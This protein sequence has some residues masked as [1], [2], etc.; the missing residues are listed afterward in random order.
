MEQ[1]E[2]AAGGA[3]TSSESALNSTRAE[4]SSLQKQA[5]DTASLLK[6]ASS[7]KCRRLTLEREHGS[8]IQGLCVRANN[9][10][11]AFCDDSAP[12]PNEND[13]ASISASLLMP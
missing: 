6:K 3:L 7:E 13:Y 10:L 11:G 2:S 4:I 1:R 9:A 12:H 8:M 5:E